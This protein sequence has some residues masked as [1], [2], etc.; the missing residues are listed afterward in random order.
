MS[1]AIFLKILQIW[2]AKCGRSRQ[3]L[4]TIATLHSEPI[5]GSLLC[6]ENSICL[7]P[8]PPSTEI[9]AKVNNYGGEWAVG[10][11]APIDS[12]YEH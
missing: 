5:F 2:K 4:I 3:V 12:Y 7:H 9:G 10:Q 11:S 1:I 6:N 8:T